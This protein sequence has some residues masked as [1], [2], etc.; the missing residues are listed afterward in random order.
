MGSDSV[1]VVSTGRHEAL[2]H[3]PI[4]SGTVVHFH[5]GFKS[6][7]DRGLGFR[8]GWRARNDTGK[9][10]NVTGLIV[11]RKEADDG[12]CS[13][14]DLRCSGEAPSFVIRENFRLDTPQ[15]RNKQ[16]F[17][18]V[19]NRVV[20]LDYIEHIPTTGKGKHSALISGGEKD[21]QGRSE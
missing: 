2:L 19:A 12:G 11:C 13:L 10:L 6:D 18:S 16:R 9:S 7:G 4:D 21:A 15:K 20:G 14:P 17:D 1:R 8:R 5:D 3:N